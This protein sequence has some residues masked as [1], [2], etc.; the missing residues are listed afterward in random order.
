MAGLRWEGASGCRGRAGSPPAAAA[1][2]RSIPAP[3]S[4]CRAPRAHQPAPLAAPARHWQPIRRYG[5]VLWR[6]GGAHLGFSSRS[7]AALWLFQVSAAVRRDRRRPG[8]HVLALMLISSLAPLLRERVPKAPKGPLCSNADPAAAPLPANLLLRGPLQAERPLR[9]TDAR[10]RPESPLQ[11]AEGCGSCHLG[12]APAESHRLTSS[13]GL[14]FTS[15]N[16]LSLLHPI[17]RLETLPSTEKGCS[18]LLHPGTLCAAPAQ[19]G[20][21][22]YGSLCVFA[23][24]F[25]GKKSSSDIPITAPAAIEAIS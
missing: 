8:E 7:L 9:Q 6:A 5:T 2:R 19:A 12:Q 1:P 4:L 17:I 18:G 24:S 16:R 14:L 20:C 11:L 15:G 21:S 10:E 25:S 13:I 3:A 22:S 23:Q